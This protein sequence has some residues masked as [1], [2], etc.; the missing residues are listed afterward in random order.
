MGARHVN[1]KTGAAGLG[2]DAKVEYTD[3]RNPVRRRHR[4][5]KQA[6]ER[7]HEQGVERERALGKLLE[8]LQASL[9]CVSSEADRAIESQ[10]V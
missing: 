5:R 4:Y 10:R 6:E 9:P 8:R 2:V 7:T 3:A 1:K